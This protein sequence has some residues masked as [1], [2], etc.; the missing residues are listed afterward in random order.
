MVVKNLDSIC[1][2]ISP[3]FVQ[4]LDHYFGFTHDDPMLIQPELLEAF[5]NL[6]SGCGYEKKGDNWPPIWVQFPKREEAL[7]R[8]THAGIPDTYEIIEEHEDGDLV[9]KLAKQGK[10]MVTTDGDIYYY[11]QHV[12]V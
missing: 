5:H 3:A 7:E 10:A 9:I 2:I 11:S 1:K 6:A 4:A 8:L 12:R